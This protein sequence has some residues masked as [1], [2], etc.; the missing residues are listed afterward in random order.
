MKY[1]Y[2][3][4]CPT[5]ISIDSCHCEIEHRKYLAVNLNGIATSKFGVIASDCAIP[6]AHLPVSCENDYPK[7]GLGFVCHIF[8]YGNS[9]FSRSSSV[10]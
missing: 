7:T 10:S 6:V 2:L 9:T 1:L 5:I 8:R 3:Q 4:L